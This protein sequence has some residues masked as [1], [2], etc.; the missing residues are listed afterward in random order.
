[1]SQ[2]RIQSERP[3]PLPSRDSE[4]FW[5]GVQRGELLGQ[6]CADCRRFRHPPRP[7]CPEC[8]C[9]SWEAVRL[10]GRGTIHAWIRP[11]HPQLP[12]FD[13]PLI[14]VLVDLEEGIRLFSNLYECEPEEIE[15]GMAVEVFFVPTRHDKAVPV[16]R[17]LSGKT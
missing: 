1:M 8:L 9:V 6:R 4:F 15:N 11:V 3:A 5:N 10:S 14:C 17:P 13:D 2:E 16:F 7:M 12:M